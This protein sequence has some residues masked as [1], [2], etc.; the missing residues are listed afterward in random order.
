MTRTLFT[1][2]RKHRNRGILL[3]ATACVALWVYVTLW[4]MNKS[5]SDHHLLLLL[6]SGCSSTASQKK[7]ATLDSFFEGSHQQSNPLLA[8]LPRHSPK[9]PIPTKTK[10]NQGDCTLETQHNNNHTHHPWSAL[11]IIIFQRDTGRQLVHQ[12][13]YYLS[14]LQPHDLVVIQHHLKEGTAADDPYTEGLLQHYGQRGV[15]VWRCTGP[16]KQ[17]RRMWSHVTKLYAPTSNF[18]VPLDV[19]EYLVTTTTFKSSTRTSFPSPFSVAWNRLDLSKALSQLRNRGVPYKLR[20]YYAVPLDCGIAS[21]DKNDEVARPQQSTVLPKQHTPMNTNPSSSSSSSCHVQVYPDPDTS[22]RRACFWKTFARG[23]DFLH[24]DQGNH[25]GGTHQSASLDTMHQGCLREGRLDFWDIA[26]SLALIHWTPTSFHEWLVHTLRGAGD[27][28]YNNYTAFENGQLN[29]TAVKNG[30]HYCREW[31]ALAERRF[32]VWQMKDLYF[33]SHCRRHAAAF[34]DNN[35]KDTPAKNNSSTTSP[36]IHYA[37]WT[38]PSC[39]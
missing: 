5:H 2:Q 16:W 24:T 8:G 1:K 21:D 38:V 33:E 39:H 6:S 3:L 13:E 7:S 30:N 25:F 23:R 20:Q 32:D 17:K 37:R 35:K 12:L 27:Y 11:R 31:Q 29:C 19:D 26:S 9:K 36:L 28:G 22:R 4:I 15:H 10:D 34:M 18:V 14:V